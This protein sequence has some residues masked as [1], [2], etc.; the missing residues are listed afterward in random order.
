MTK[1]STSL[2]PEAG[3]QA[4]QRQEI[5]DGIPLGRPGETKDIAHLL[6]FLLGDESSFISGVAYT[7]DGGI[8]A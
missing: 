8:T 1:L 3:S 2:N 7:I 6:T 5:I 4:T